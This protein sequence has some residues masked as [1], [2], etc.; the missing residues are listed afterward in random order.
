MSRNVQFKSH[1]RRNAAALAL[2]TVLAA[3]LRFWR[4][5]QVPPGFH[6]D[7]AYEA[8]E[9]VRVLSQPGY[10]PIFFPGNFGVEPIFIYLTSL[11]FRVFGE[12]PTVMRGVAAV[13]GTLTIPAVCL[14]ARELARSDERPSGGWLP[15]ATP[16]L[17]AAVLATMRWHIQFSRTGIE[18]VLVPLLLCLALWAFWRGLRCDHPAAWMAL[19]V[20]VGLGPYADPAGR[21]LP[22]VSVLLVALV[23]LSD[24]SR[25][26]GRWRGLM[27]AGVVAAL[28]FAPLGWHWLRHPDQ[29]LLRSSQVAA[30]PTAGGPLQNLLAG[31]GMFLIRGDMDVRNNVP[32]M[33]ALDVLMGIPFVVGLLAVCWRWRL[34]KSRAV[35]FAGLLLAGGV[36]LMPT[37]FSEYAPHFRRALGVTPVVALLCG[38][39]L[40]TMLGRPTKAPRQVEDS[41]ASG[42]PDSSGASSA[43]MDRLRGVGR[44]VVVAAILLGST[45]YG[46]AAYFTRWAGSPALYY[47]YD[48][49]LWEIGEYVLTLPPDEPVYITPRPEGDTT[50]AFAWREGRPVRHFDGRH[51]FIAATATPTPGPSPAAAGEGGG[52]LHP[53]TYIVIEHEDFRGSRL[54]QEL[55]PQA[56]EARQFLDR[57]GKVYAR[58]WRVP[59]TQAVARTPEASF[60]GVWPGIEL[61]GFDLE[62]AVFSGKQI[63]YLQLWWRAT[64]PVGT[65][66]TV[67]THLLGPAKPD[68]SLLWAAADARP[69]QGSVPTRAWVA[70]DL[71]LDEYLLELPAD[72]PSGRYTIEVGLYD[73]AQGGRRANASEPVG[74]DHLILGEVVKQ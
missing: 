25:L 23:W 61:I 65:D 56:V 68:G 70:G 62:R 3:A 74:Q 9:A 38:L 53:A 58:A 57:E 19:G 14:L 1:P 12:S 36:M 8:L 7:E 11:A 35:A 28:T 4:L 51:A 73:P 29:L 66:W 6:Y 30:G 39:G 60:R 46:A 42:V 41:T 54:V 2:I 17:A 16:L 59:D 63:V 43:L 71:I 20:T 13:L 37:V 24:R 49:G 64:A 5:D 18:P 44:A 22:V 15:P 52:A 10:H 47:A 32:G 50:L 31:L 27:I 33:P 48:Q 45:A 40:A 55:Y 72:A 26:Q 69:G 67:F 21:L 34:D